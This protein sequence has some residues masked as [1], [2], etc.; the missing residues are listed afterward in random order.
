M[1]NAHP[2]G[3]HTQRPK[4]EPVP[5]PYT[6]ICPEMKPASHL[7]R[8]ILVFVMIINGG[9]EGPNHQM[10]GTRTRKMIICY[11]DITL[12]PHIHL[13]SWQD[14]WPRAPLSISSAICVQSCCVVYARSSQDRFSHALLHQHG[15]KIKWVCCYIL[16]SPLSCG[17]NSLYIVWWLHLMHII[18]ITNNL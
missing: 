4:P 3:M 10:Y 6:H 5:V 17:S 16:L 7:G 15:H 11:G 18:T 9:S 1:S 2:T 13:S 12:I 14:G 8:P